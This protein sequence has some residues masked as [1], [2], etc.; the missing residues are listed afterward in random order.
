[1]VICLEQGVNDLHTVQHKPLPPHKWLLNGYLF[2]CLS[3]Y[4]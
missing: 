3:T 4:F 1:M 2:D